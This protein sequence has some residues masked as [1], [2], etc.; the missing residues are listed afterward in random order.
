[1][2]DYKAWLEAYDDPASGLSW[3]VQAVRAA[4]S[5][6]LDAA[7]G[8]V[9]IISACSGDGRD[10][11]GALAARADAGKVTATLLEIHPDI[12]ERARR[13][14]DQAGLRQLKAC[15]LDAGRSDAY[16][17]LV[18]V[19]LVL[20]VGIFGNIDDSD[21]HRTIAA[22]P[23]LCSPGATVVWSRGR[24]GSLIDRNDEVRAA[25]RVAGFTELDYRTHDCGHRP[26]V[27]VVRYDGPPIPLERGRTWFTFRR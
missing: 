4:I 17:G 22:S 7:V 12:A 1:M 25:F 14:A 21:L 15:T 19:D 9:R 2:R 20:L 23:Q 13:A 6:A 18:P 24:G 5:A 11:I 8:P 26:A 3:R 27:G 16:A 10:V